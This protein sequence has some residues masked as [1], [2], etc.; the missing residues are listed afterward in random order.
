MS[1]LGLMSRACPDA[2]HIGGTSERCSPEMNG[3]EAE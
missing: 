1:R 3:L 2:A